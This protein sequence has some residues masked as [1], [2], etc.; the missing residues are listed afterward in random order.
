MVVNNIVKMVDTATSFFKGKVIVPSNPT[1]EQ[2]FSLNSELI[3]D[4]DQILSEVITYL[5][6]RKEKEPMLKL[7][8]VL[9]RHLANKDRP[10]NLVFTFLRLFDSYNLALKY[11]GATNPCMVEGMFDELV[12]RKVL[13]R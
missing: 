12:R 2:W 11:K 10:L 9:D 8:N 7:L 6:R 13:K 4:V 3:L 5:M 1:F